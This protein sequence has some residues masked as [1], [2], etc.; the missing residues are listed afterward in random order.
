MQINDRGNDR[1]TQP[2]ARM[3]MAFLAAI[4]PLQYRSAFL[5]RD[6]RAAVLDCDMQA[7]VVLRRKNAHA[8]TFWGE[9]DGVAHQVGQRLE[10][11]FAVTVQR[12]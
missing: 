4:E 8:A 10:Q 2:E 7:L 11:Q 9:L 1:Q 12:R 3:A 6:P 5:F